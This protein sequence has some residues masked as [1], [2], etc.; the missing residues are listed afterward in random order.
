MRHSIPGGPAKAT[1]PCVLEA[2]GT[3]CASRL[4]GPVI[5]A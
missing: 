1:D 3:G 5:V 4:P 2:E